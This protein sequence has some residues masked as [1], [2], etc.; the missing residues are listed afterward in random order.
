[1]SPLIVIIVKPSGCPDLKNITKV[2]MH[3]DKY[4]VPKFEEITTTLTGSLEY[5]DI[6]LKDTYLQMGVDVSVRKYL[7]I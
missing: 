6:N 2:K 1:M 4:P 3:P 7:T 5:S